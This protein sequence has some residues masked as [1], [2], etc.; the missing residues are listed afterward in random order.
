ML[1]NP[2]FFYRPPLNDWMPTRLP[3]LPYVTLNGPNNKVRSGEDN[4]ISKR[5]KFWR[6]VPYNTRL[7][8]K[9]TELE[10]KGRY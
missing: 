8:A 7:H 1:N 3:N 5:M 2:L 4:K 9:I 10:A 6:K